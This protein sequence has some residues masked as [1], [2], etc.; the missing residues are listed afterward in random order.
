M[1]LTSSD[2]NA[3]NRL[4][5]KVGLGYGV[6]FFFFKRNKF[7]KTFNKFED[8]KN[9]NNLGMKNNLLVKFQRPK[10]IVTYIIITIDMRNYNPEYFQQDY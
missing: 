8:E 1:A 9:N 2:A 3:L 4:N 6:F 5:F 7:E 10:I